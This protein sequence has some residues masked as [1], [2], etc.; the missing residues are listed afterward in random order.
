M[1]PAWK[2]HLNVSVVL[3]ITSA[4]CFLIKS[5]IIARFHKACIYLKG[6]SV[7]KEMM[8]IETFHYFGFFHTNLIF[9]LGL[10]EGRTKFWILCV[11]PTHSMIPWVL[12]YY[13]KHV[14]CDY[15]QMMDIFVSYSAC[16]LLGSDWRISIYQ[17]TE[18]RTNKNSQT[19]DLKQIFLID[20][21]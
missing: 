10:W 15:A 8:L 13:L 4:K 7:I 2:I 6:T 14:L 19:T 21:A 16:K 3:D 17:A 11:N 9:C 20:T 12:I 5:F 18:K 1:L